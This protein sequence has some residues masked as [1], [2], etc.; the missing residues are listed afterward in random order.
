MELVIFY[1]YWKE[2]VRYEEMEVDYDI[3]EIRKKQE[4]ESITQYFANQIEIAQTLNLSKNPQSIEL[5]LSNIRSSPGFVIYSSIDE[6]RKTNIFM[7][8]Y[9]LSFTRDN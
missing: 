3:D 8:D 6:A 2:I 9:M 4:N 1:P 7:E 5:L